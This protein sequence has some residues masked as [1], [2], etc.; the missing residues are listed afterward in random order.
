MECFLKKTDKNETLYYKNINLPLIERYRPKQFSDILLNDNLKL[1]LKSILKSKQLPNLIIIGEAS[2]GKTSTVLYI[3]K[4]I[5]KD[6]YENNVLELNASDDRGLNMIQTTILPFCKKKSSFNKLVI[7]DESDSITQK[8]QNLLN[9]IIAEYRNTTRFIFICNE[10]YKINESIQSRCMIINFPRISKENLKNKLV[11]ICNNESIN[12]TQKGI[13]TLMFYSNYDIRQCINN[14]ECILFTY[15][16]V[17]EKIINEIIDKPRLNNI[18]SI[19]LNCKN[20]NFI[21]SLNLVNELY[22]NGHS[23]NDILLSFLNYIQKE[24]IDYLSEKEKLNLY[25]VICSSYIKVNNGINTLLQLYACITN[26]NN[27][28]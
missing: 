3:A 9:N 11:S 14:L 21:E 28:F 13:D 7:L 5:Y 20:K 10:N 19:L 12:Y 27:L 18:K 8:A 26:I 16:D 6:D 15:N 25:S 17:T 24:K 23:P 2:T 4:K 1:K 22:F